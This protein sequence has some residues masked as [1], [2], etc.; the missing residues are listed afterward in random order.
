MKRLL[1]CFLIIISIIGVVLIT[2]TAF[3]NF[4]D[5]NPYREKIEKMAT[6]AMGRQLRI[7][8]PIDINLF[9]SP[10]VI[11]NEVALANAP[12]GSEPT[13]VSVGHVDAAISLLSLFSDMIII[14]QVHLNDVIVLLEKNDRQLGNWVIGSI[15]QSGKSE[16]KHAGSQKHSKQATTGSTSDVLGWSESSGLFG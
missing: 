1:G 9:P 10:E 7:N 8:G 6:K 16:E 15:D 3:L 5:L 11:L 12:W 14:K 2:G 13:M 4:A